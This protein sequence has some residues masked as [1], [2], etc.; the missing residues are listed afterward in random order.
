MWI[1]ISKNID[2]IHPNKNES[3]YLLYKFFLRSK[4]ILIK[5]NNLG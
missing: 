5:H 4:N 3:S 1:T 2:N